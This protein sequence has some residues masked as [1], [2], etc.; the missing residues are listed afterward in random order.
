MK[1]ARKRFRETVIWRRYIV[2]SVH[3]RNKKLRDQL[4]EFDTLKE[5]R[6]YIKKEAPEFPDHKLHVELMEGIWR[7]YVARIK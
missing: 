3:K 2:F 6:K 5:A 4:A 7:K 1:Q